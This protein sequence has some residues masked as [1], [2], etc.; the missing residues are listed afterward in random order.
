M[1]INYYIAHKGALDTYLNLGKDVMPHFDIHSLHVGKRSGNHFTFQAVVSDW[2]I[3]ADKL[4]AVYNKPD[5]P[6][7]QDLISLRDCYA[8]DTDNVIGA[9][10]GGKYDNPWVIKS[11]QG[12]REVLCRPEIAIFDEDSNPIGTDVFLDIVEGAQ[13]KDSLTTYP[14]GSIEA[15][16][17]AYDFLDEGYV[18]TPRIF[19]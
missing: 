8:I 7:I 11:V 12:W 15:R 3:L 2:N 17:S 6:M 13:R 10:L 14:A 1:S 5:S 16:I 4:G 9:T 19:C 18:F